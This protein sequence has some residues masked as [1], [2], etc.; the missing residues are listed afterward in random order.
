MS[1]D[2]GAETGET[3]V[4][5]TENRCP[6][7]TAPMNSQGKCTQC[8][9]VEQR[10]AS[11]YLPVDQIKLE[12]AGFQKWFC[13]TLSEGVSMTIVAISAH[14]GI[15][16]LLLLCVT[17]SFMFEYYVTLVLLLLVAV[18]YL[19]FVLKG[20]DLRNNPRAELSWFLKPFWHGLLVTMRAR[21]WAGV[22]NQQKPRTIDKRQAPLTD[23]MFGDI[24]G[25]KNCQVLD[26]EGTLISDSS[27]RSLYGHKHLCCL[28]LRK[29]KV[30]SEAV[31]RLQ[32]ANPDVWIWS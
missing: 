14:V 10:F 5:A 32:Q 29:T 15:G 30:T 13:E 24:E 21:K 6:K 3:L 4:P 16:M 26:L 8:P 11:A 7:C 23:D 18:A 27:L 25:L 31:M 28:V 2:F 9:Y 1:R 17:A 22:Q 20:Y 12:L 19:A